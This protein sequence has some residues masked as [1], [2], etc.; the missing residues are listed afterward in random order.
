M[1]ARPEPRKA[2]P[3][4]SALGARNTIIDRPIEPVASTAIATT[5]TTQSPTSSM[6]V[7][8]P[9]DLIQRA[10]SAY[11]HTMLIPED[12]KRSFKDFVM[13]AIQTEVTR[14]ERKYNN[15]E[16]FPE[17]GNLAPGSRIQ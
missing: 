3:Q 5:A 11:L 15:A 8:G 4:K 13:A 6:T 9:S 17:R 1:A 16:P 14:L 10:K 2:T 7:T 12:A